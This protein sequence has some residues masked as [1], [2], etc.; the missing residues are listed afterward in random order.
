[1]ETGMTVS[2][3]MTDVG[4]V[5]EAAI[6]MVGTVAQTVVSNPILYLPI[7]IGLCGIGVAFFNRLKQ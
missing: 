1:M 3:L 5:F 6:D 7:V 2:S 4:S